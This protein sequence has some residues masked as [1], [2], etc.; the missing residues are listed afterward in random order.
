MQCNWKGIFPALTTSFTENLEIDKSAMERRIEEQLEAGVEGFVMCGS[1]GENGT[2]SA[3]EKQEILRIALSVSNKRVPVLLGVAETTTAKA[4]ACAK[5]SAANGADGLMVL[6][7]MQ[8]VSDP[9]ETMQ[10]FRTVAAATDLPIMIYNNPVAYSTDI[11][12]AMFAELADEPKFVALKESS[13]DVRRISEIIKL[14]GDR[15]QMFVGVDN[16]ALESFM[17]GAIGWV[18]GLVSAF[19]RETVVLIKLAEAGRYEEARALY[20]WFLPLLDLDVTVKFIQN[21]KLAG[22]MAGVCNEYVRPPRLP[23]AGDER[24]EVEKI[25]NEALANRPELPNI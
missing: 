18:A 19:P 20:R 22:A 17:L 23:L 5:T 10:H 6:P 24:D 2:L 12:P 3:E 25:V 4:C 15:Y 9:R 11:T 14:T 13:A 1:L 21:I 16:L 7:G 8:Y